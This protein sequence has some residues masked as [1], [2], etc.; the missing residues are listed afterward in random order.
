ML[1]VKLC[2]DYEM[3]QLQPERSPTLR[4]R[5]SARLAPRTPA[6]ERQRYDAERRYQV[7]DDDEDIM[8]PPKRAACIPQCLKQAIDY[9]FNV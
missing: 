6:Y 1:G 4:H 7:E 9:I 8:A 3:A 5:R 2:T